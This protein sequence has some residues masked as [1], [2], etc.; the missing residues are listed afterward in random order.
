[1]DINETYSD[2]GLGKWF[3]E[4]W[5]DISRKDKSGKHPPCGASAKKGGRKKDQKKAYPKCRPAAKA[6]A[7]SPELKKKA[8]AQKRRAEKKKS[9]HKGR[10][11][12][13]VSHKN[14]K[15]DIMNEQEIFELN[16]A[17]KNKPNNSSLWSKAKSMAKQKFDVYPCAYANAWAA[18][19]YK[20][21]KGK[22]KKVAESFT[23]NVLNN[24]ILKEE[25][26]I[27]QIESAID[28]NKNGVR[29]A[30]SYLKQFFNK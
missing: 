27:K 9:H 18:K 2:S 12:V 22:W 20:K 29:Q 15:E 6:A 3:G 14:L 26:S 25:A 23:Q 24:S 21:K 4:K 17:S 28:N 7:M 11:P 19:C 16:E 8:T 5:V 10:K 13:V 30:V 1:M